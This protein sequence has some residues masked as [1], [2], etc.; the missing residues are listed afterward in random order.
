MGTKTASTP[1][2]A[3]STCH[4]EPEGSSV[5]RT[6]AV[7]DEW[8]QGAPFLP[9]T[10]PPPVRNFYP[11]QSG[12]PSVNAVPRYNILLVEDNVDIREGLAE[13]LAEDGFEVTQAST[14]EEGLAQLGGRRFD[15]VV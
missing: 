4:A 1:P 3:P 12:D 2:T 7:A 15:L 6:A 8:I 13:M 9:L 14:A 5:A 10:R 11:G